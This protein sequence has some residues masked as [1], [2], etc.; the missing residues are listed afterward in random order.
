MTSNVSSGNY[1][2]YVSSKP[3]SSSMSKP[4]PKSAVI[5]TTQAIGTTTLLQKQAP[6]STQ[7]LQRPYPSYSGGSPNYPALNESSTLDPLVQSLASMHLQ[8]SPKPGVMI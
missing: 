3:S 4:L 1:S 6:I 5:G 2:S 7:N 8:S